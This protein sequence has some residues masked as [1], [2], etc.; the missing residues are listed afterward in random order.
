MDTM[1]PELRYAMRRYLRV[2]IPCLVL[3]ALGAGYVFYRLFFDEPLTVDLP[4]LIGLGVV[5]AAALTTLRPS[6]LLVRA[7]IFRKP[8]R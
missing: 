3:M 8:S 6:I 7:G 4:L 2:A 5:C 1:S